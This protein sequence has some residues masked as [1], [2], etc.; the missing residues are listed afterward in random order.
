M[1]NHKFKKQFGQNFL[2]GDKFA[3]ALIEPLKITQ[4]DLVIEIGPG[5]GMVTKKLLETGAKTIAIDVDY[6]VIPKLIKK[7]GKEP[8]FR[9]VHKDIL[10]VNLLKIVE[11]FAELE[12]DN[13]FF[14]IKITGSLPYNISK[15]I[16]SRLLFINIAEEKINIEAMS[17]I[18][19]DEVSKSYS[20]KPPKATF[21]G[22]TTA[23]ISTVKKLQ[24]IP[25]S[26]FYPRPKVDGGILFIKPKDTEQKEF[27]KIKKLL[28]I[29]FSSPRKTLRNN[30][31]N[32]KKYSVKSI[33]AAFL[34]LE[35]SDNKRASEVEMDEWAE[36]EKMLEVM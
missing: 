7:F 27:E 22:M 5:D 24:S 15:E 33:D 18:V 10:K 36:L 17:F 19:Q 13:D 14:N 12:T 6:D 8:N 25:A 30:L 31:V 20:A 23:L 9:L 2:R 32:S 1:R 3:K 35:F 11:E 21:L 28:K 4:D 34:K 29:G 16:I 26:Q